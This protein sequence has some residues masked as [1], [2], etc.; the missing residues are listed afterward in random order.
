[1]LERPPI[2]RQGDKIAIISTARKISSIELKPAIDLLN[3]WGLE[4]ILGDTINAEDHQYA[5][6]DILRANDL[7]T[8]IDD[9]DI[10]AILFGR[11]GY[12][13]VR[14]LDKINF[15]HFVHHPKWLIGY[16]DYTLLFNYINQQYGIQTLHASMPINFPYNTPDSIDSIKSVIFGK[17]P[18]Y[19]WKGK[20]H[21]FSEGISG[22]IVGGNLSIFYSLLG[23]NNGFNWAHKIVMIED[24]GEYYYHVD[25]M[26]IA[27]KNA[28]KLSELKALI[29]GGFTD[30]NDNQIPF[31]KTAQ[32]IIIEHTID[33][34]YPIFCDAPFGHQNQN[35][36][37]ALGSEVRM[38]NKNDLIELI[39]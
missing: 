14:I 16:S 9:K 12:G 17:K 10:K 27:L 25:R 34:G 6:T 33:Y 7:Q 22:E 18:F 24:I 28:N 37:L 8:Y 1:M 29:I 4:V 31:G 38:D 5:G 32:D 19:Q 23:T 30:M 36:A 13:T 11:G 3:S 35:L 39:S 26:M 2:L 20:V 15:H 21:H